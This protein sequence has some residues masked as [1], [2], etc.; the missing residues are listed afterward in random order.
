MAIRGLG[1]LKTQQR[2]W[3]RSGA[4]EV[5]VGRPI[6]FAPF[7]TESQITARLHNEVQKLLSASAL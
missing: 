4:L 1:E 6:R 5:R 7:D 3:F 2:S